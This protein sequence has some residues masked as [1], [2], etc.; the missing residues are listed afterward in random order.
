[1]I[2]NKL[3]YL[4]V[5]SIITVAFLY[6][7]D[8]VMTLSY[9][10]KIFLKMVLFTIFPMIY[11]IQTGDNIL[12]SSLRNLKRDRT[13]NH[14]VN[15][16]AVLGFIVFSIIIVAYII[17]N[18]YID[19]DQLIL[20]FQEKYKINKG[21]L[22]SYSIYLV[23]V[24]SFLEEFF[25]RGFIFL[26]IKKLG[27]KKT[28]YVFSSILFALYHIANFQNWF[29]VIMFILVLFGL[30]VGGCIFNYLDDKPETFLNSWFVHIC[31]D[32]AIVLIGFYIFGIIDF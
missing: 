7:F 29:H 6:I 18:K 2:K 1:M 26:N 17:M 4:V 21:N 20:E 5:S 3:R 13:D 28:A 32:L 10:N 8:Q 31:A 23:F 12:K 14:R 27:M 9:M 15:L 16:G 30:F 25:F 22:M 24:N 19:S 11:I